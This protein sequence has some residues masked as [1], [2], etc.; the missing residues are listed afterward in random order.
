M[1]KSSIILTSCVVILLC[2]SII[3]GMSYALFTD[4]GRARNHLRAGKLDIVLTRTDLEYTF[5]NQDGELEIV[6]DST[7][8][9]FTS[10]TKENI[11]GMDPNSARIVPTGYYEAE[12]QISN[13]GNVA[14]DYTVELTLLG[15]VTPMSQQLKATV[16]HPDG[17]TESKMLSELQGK[18]LVLSTGKMKVTDEP[19]TFRVRIEM[20]DD[21]EYNA[22]RLPGQ[23]VI[24]NNAAQN[25]KMGFDIN[26]SAVQATTAVYTGQN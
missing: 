18:S 22:N 14:F 6:R 21:A 26:I 2:V 25:N 11:F 4:S 5:L 23:P 9:D 17:S 15:K 24:S 19:E 13:N 20:L 10:T 12:L 3:S 7:D 8:V 1:K 16:I